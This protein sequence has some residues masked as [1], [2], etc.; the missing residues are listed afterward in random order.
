M[1]SMLGAIEFANDFGT[2]SRFTPIISRDPSSKRSLMIWPKGGDNSLGYAYNLMYSIID[3]NGKAKTDQL[4]DYNSLG[5]Y[6]GECFMQYHNT[7]DYYCNPSL[8]THH[9][10]SRSNYLCIYTD[11]ALLI[12]WGL[13]LDNNHAGT[14]S[15]GTER[16]TINFPT[17]F[18]NLPYVFASPF[19]GLSMGG[20]TWL[21]DFSVNVLTASKTSCTIARG[22]SPQY[23]LNNDVNE[24]VP[25]IMWIAIGNR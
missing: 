6:L 13:A 15:G 5:S 3:S 20:Q 16:L 22:H 25:A 12:Q 17:A 24:L 9:L 1:S 21:D 18:S 14:L 7:F 8:P 2:K 11:P 4:V 23:Y 10:E 19:C